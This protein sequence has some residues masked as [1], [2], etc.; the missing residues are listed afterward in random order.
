MIKT[1][2][3]LLVAAFLAAPAVA[4]AS[5][6]DHQDHKLPIC[7]R[8]ASDSNPWVIISPDKA[9]WKAHLDLHVNHNPKDG[10]GDKFAILWS[11]GVY[12]CTKEPPPPPPNDGQ[13]VVDGIV[14]GDP[15]VILH[16]HSMWEEDRILKIRY[17]DAR[18]KEVVVR[19]R[20]APPGHKTY[21]PF[22]V[23]GKTIFSVRDQSSAHRF[24]PGELLFRTWVGPKQNI[25][26]CERTFM[27]T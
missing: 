25:G 27:I 14:C 11:D 21:H 4:V 3:S 17:V 9:S 19:Y 18:T 2:A 22:W 12:R 6:P 15:R 8:T 7:H 10:R 5:Q 24:D 16:S 23:Q 13:I 1:I 26:P 20:K